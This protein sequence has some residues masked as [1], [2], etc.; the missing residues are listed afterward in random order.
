MLPSLRPW[1]GL[2]FAPLELFQGSLVQIHSR[3]PFPLLLPLNDLASSF[4]VKRHHLREAPW[5]PTVYLSL[6]SSLPVQME[7]ISLL[8]SRSILFSGSHLFKLLKRSHFHKALG[9]IN[10]SMFPLA[11][12]FTN[13]FSSQP[14][15]ILKCFPLTRCALTPFSESLSLLSIYTR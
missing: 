15:E 4:S 7:A 13:S 1:E 8:L 10:Q 6:S 3:R 5:L 2:S 9:F 14:L 11:K 12:D